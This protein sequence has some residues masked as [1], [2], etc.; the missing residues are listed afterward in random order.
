[1]NKRNLL[2]PSHTRYC[3]LS[4]IERVIDI[5]YRCIE[6]KHTQ[7]YLLI[8]SAYCSKR[9]LSTSPFIQSLPRLVSD[10]PISALLSNTERWAGTCTGGKGGGSSGCPIFNTRSLCMHIHAKPHICRP[11]HGQGLLLCS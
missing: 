2:M 8:A 9:V 10:R 1:M 3:S 7:P 5:G 4:A 11:S 6:Y